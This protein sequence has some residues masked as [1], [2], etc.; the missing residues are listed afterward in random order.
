MISRYGENAVESRGK[1]G[2]HEQQQRNRHKVLSRGHEVQNNWR[3][4]KFKK[5]LM[6]KRKYIP[7]EDSCGYL[8]ARRETSDWGGY[9]REFNGNGENMRMSRERMVW[10]C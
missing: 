1:L 7:A 8:C 9:W 3:K 5:Q 6:T 4:T 2:S 10:V